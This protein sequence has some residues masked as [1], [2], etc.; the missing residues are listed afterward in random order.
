MCLLLMATM[1]CFSQELK[2]S[3]IEIKYSNS[4]HPGRIVVTYIKNKTSRR[5]NVRFKNEYDGNGCSIEL[6]KN[7]TREKGMSVAID[8]TCNIVMAKFKED[9][10]FIYIYSQP[11]PKTESDNNEKKE[12]VQ[13]QDKKEQTETK[14]KTSPSKNV[15]LT[16]ITDAPQKLII[17]ESIKKQEQID[18]NHVLAEFQK[19]LDTIPFY[20]SSDNAKEQALVNDCIIKLMKSGEDNKAYVDTLKSLIENCREEIRKNRVEV[21]EVLEK[22]LADYNKYN[23]EN[24]DSCIN[25]MRTLV[26]EKIGQREDLINKLENEVEKQNASH[27]YG[28]I[29][30]QSVTVGAGL[31]ILIMILAI[32][33]ERTNSKDK[34]KKHQSIP[35]S[36]SKTEVAS[37]I[38]VRRKTTAI[39]RKQSLEDVIENNAYLKIDCED[40]CNDS[41]V[42]RMYLKNTCIKEIYN[43]YAEDL[44]N[45]NNPKEDGCMVLGRWVHDSEKNEYYVSLEHVV[46]PG[47]DAV[48][49]E[50]ELNFGGKIKLKVTEKLRKLRRDTGMQYDLTSW[51]HSHPGLGVFFSNSDTNVQLQLKHPMHPNFLT[52]IVIDI[53]TPQQELGI[54]TF[55]KDSSV[56]SKNELKKLYSLEE[57][58]K[59]AIE[60]ER[61]TLL[62][63]EHFDTLSNARTH[64]DKCAGI[65]L[66]N[67]S[68]IDMEMLAV[69]Q[70]N[71][72]VGFVQGFTQQQGLKTEN[73]ITDIVKVDAEQHDEIIGC[74]VISA[75]CSIPSIKR[76]IAKEMNKVN[77]VIVYSTS[78]GMVTSIPVIEGEMCVEENYYGEQ[79]LEELKIWTRRKR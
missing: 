66:S 44:R 32:W 55:K 29:N 37:A 50:Y 57:M 48:F 54:F 39:L 15:V 19:Y 76:I 79:P 42:R 23:I 71:G 9:N 2:K 18:G 70:R 77:F 7:E 28:L 14:G 58:Y 27:V 45:P 3:D 63:E 65:N 16:S 30:I 20:S 33:Y 52:A 43:M 69:E 1:N 26:S 4:V 61:K 24:K 40:F 47:D 51:V 53:L 59:W 21:D 64:T 11:K 5:V 62:S 25:K 72:L 60:S 12:Q 6:A 74:F 46:M 13:F 36:V 49:T 56:H 31:L 34:K 38:V 78:T 68:V 73:I 41:A 75:H 67:S 35:N 8:I 17:K 10:S 22:F